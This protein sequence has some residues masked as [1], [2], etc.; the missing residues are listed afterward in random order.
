[1]MIFEKAWNLVKDVD[2]KLPKITDGPPTYTDKDAILAF[3]GSKIPNWHSYLHPFSNDPMIDART[4]DRFGIDSE[5]G[6][7]TSNYF[8]MGGPKDD[9]YN[10]EF[11]SSVEYDP[12]TGEYIPTMRALFDEAKFKDM[13][14]EGIIT[15]PPR[16]DYDIGDFTDSQ[17]DF[18]D[19]FFLEPTS[20]KTELLDEIERASLVRALM[21]AGIT[22]KEIMEMALDETSFIQSRGPWNSE[23]P[24]QTT[25][26]QPTYVSGEGNK[27]G[28]YRTNRL[29]GDDLDVDPDLWDRQGWEEDA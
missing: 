28:V 3:R 9:F 20:G 24:F 19:A 2:F 23:T 21:N 7:K 6:Y 29:G 18:E 10:D 25:I 27:D 5:K 8:E 15:V 1:M 26:R 16:M 17:Q 14:R 11:Q 4:G 12:F 13:V 22:D